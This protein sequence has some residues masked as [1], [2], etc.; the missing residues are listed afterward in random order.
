MSQ[1]ELLRSRI[2]Q[3]KIKNVLSKYD[4]KD[5]KKCANAAV[6][7]L[8]SLLPQHTFSIKWNLSYKEITSFCG[9]P[10][11]EQF[12][13]RKI[14]PDGGVIWMDNKY[15]ILISEIKHQGTN[16]ERQAEGKEKQATGN[17]IERYGKNLMALQTMFS[18]K[19][20]LP[21]VVFCWGC[22]FAKE[23]TT[24]LSKLYA[25]NCF[26]E[27]NKMY[28]KTSIGIKPHNVFYREEKWMNEEITSIMVELAYNYALLYLQG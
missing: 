1:H 24:V 23:Q 7:I 11:L 6:E 16:K 19:I 21:A 26:Q 22:D 17:A 20:F 10:L 13:D 27:M 9:L 2:E 3:H 25:L 15:P 14:L 12:N 8:S 5:M 4:N 18:Q 28:L